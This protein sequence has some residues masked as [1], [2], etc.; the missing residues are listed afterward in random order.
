MGTSVEAVEMGRG[1][2]DGCDLSLTRC[3]FMP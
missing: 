2:G 3:G 1:S